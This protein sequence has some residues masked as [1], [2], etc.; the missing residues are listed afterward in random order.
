MTITGDPHAVAN[1]A[2]LVR[3]VM[4]NGPSA[5][6]QGGYGAGAYGGGYGTY[7]GGGGGGGY[8]APVASSDG[9]AVR[10]FV[11]VC[12]FWYVCSSVQ[13]VCV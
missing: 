8:T 13:C 2:A 10:F 1:A 5:L 11:C 3:A 7:G 12:V 9:Q 4:E 6:Q